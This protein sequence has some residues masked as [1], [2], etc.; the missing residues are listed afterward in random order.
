[1]ESESAVQA[2]STIWKGE[3]ES[4]GCHRKDCSGKSGDYRELNQGANRAISPIREAEN[5]LAKE[6]DERNADYKIFQSCAHTPESRDEVEVETR[7]HLRR[8]SQPA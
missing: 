3:G 6:K 8:Y 4:G 2:V 1:M 7:R 5:P